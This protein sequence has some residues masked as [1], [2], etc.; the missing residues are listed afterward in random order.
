MHTLDDTLEYQLKWLG[1]LGGLLIPCVSH[2]SSLSGCESVLSFD[3]VM[4]LRFFR[5]QRVL[6][7]CITFSP[8]ERV[9][10]VETV[11]VWGQCLLLFRSVL[12][13]WGC[14]QWES[15]TFILCHSLDL[16]VCWQSSQMSGN[17]PAKVSAFYFFGDIFFLE[18][19]AV[20]SC[21]AAQ[22]SW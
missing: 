6:T 5:M 14:R 4:C 15:C 8:R 17:T 2:P 12:D 18:T 19:R 22:S 20:K 21:C 3:Y 7:C 10:P 11:T 9:F 13:Q 16:V 1:F